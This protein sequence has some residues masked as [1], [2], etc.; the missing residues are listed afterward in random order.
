MHSP[1]SWHTLSHLHCSNPNA[2]LIQSS[3]HSCE[4]EKAARCCTWALLRAAWC[5]NCMWI[6]DTVTKVHSR[7]INH[8]LAGHCLVC[9]IQITSSHR[10]AWEPFHGILGPG[11]LSL[12]SA[13]TQVYAW[14]ERCWRGNNVFREKATAWSSGNC[15]QTPR[16]TLPSHTGTLFPFP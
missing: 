16:I 2:A 5:C 4:A 10:T 15:A 13:E 9:A 8:T 3:T 6:K 11:G 7:K 1:G 14:V 12:I